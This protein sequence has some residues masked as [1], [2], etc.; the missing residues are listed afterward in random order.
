MQLAVPQ[1]QQE[2]LL[3]VGLMAPYLRQHAM[4]SLLAEMASAIKQ[5]GSNPYQRDTMCPRLVCT[6]F[7]NRKEQRSPLSPSQS[8]VR[9]LPCRTSY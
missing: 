3:Q 6:H 1:C 9:A 4:E 5:P 8:A 7:K 2:A